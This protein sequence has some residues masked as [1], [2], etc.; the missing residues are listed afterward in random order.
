MT[1]KIRQFNLMS[2][3]RGVYDA[4]DPPPNVVY[5]FGVLKGDAA[6]V[7]ALM[8][9]KDAETASA[10]AEY[11]SGPDRKYAAAAGAPYGAGKY[12]GVCALVVR[13]RQA[14]TLLRSGDSQNVHIQA[15]AVG[16]VELVVLHGFRGAPEELRQPNA[17]A[18]AR[19]LAKAVGVEPPTICAFFITGD[20]EI[21][22]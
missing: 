4:R 18:F 21:D 9:L 2:V 12:R 7:Y 3:A 10:L 14:P 11:F 17:E 13:G 5:D 6:D 20:P 22:L 1:L 8:G 16:P 19:G 15:F